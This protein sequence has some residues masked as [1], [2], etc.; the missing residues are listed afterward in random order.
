LSE[1]VGN[2]A[3][4]WLPLALC[5]AVVAAPLWWWRPERRFLL[6]LL[7]AFFI[8]WLQM[9]VTVEAGGSAHHIILLWPHI[10]AFAAVALAAAMPVRTAA[11]RRWAV[12]AV[13][14]LVA[15]SNMLLMNECLAG[16]IR[17]GP[18]PMWSDAVY[19]LAKSIEESW[20]EVVYVAD[21]G[22]GDSLRMFLGHRVKVENAIEPFHRQE[23]D[24]D[25]RHR[26]V[27]R[28]ERPASVFVSYTDPRDMFPT[29]KRLLKQ[30]AA[31]AGYDI[32]MIEVV[33]DRRGRAVF[34]I[35][36]F[37]TAPK[38]STGG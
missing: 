3:S 21:W 17:F 20:P 1:A 9:L 37:A 7:T 22:M 10:A 29:A 25:E 11:M 18:S 35:F 32:E 2:P 30:G 13:A 34:E 19:P 27:E 26:I 16:L 4:G 24:E 15:A 14:A 12:V 6:F 38:V 5:L 36:R 23:L 28:I 31:E 33:H 8:A